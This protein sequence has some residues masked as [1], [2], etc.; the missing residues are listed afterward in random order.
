MNILIVE[1]DLAQ[2]DTWKRQIERNNVRKGL[3]YSADYAESYEQAVE[4]IDS[5]KYDAA[6]LDVRLQNPDG[7]KDAT[8][9]GN[10]VRDLLLRFEIVL[11]AHV[12]GEPKAIDF[13]D[14]KNEG[15]VRV[16]TKG[17]STEDDRSVHD[18][19]LDWLEEKSNIVITMKKVQSNIASKMAD[20]FYSS[21]WPRWESWQAVVD[22]NTEFI[23]SSITRHIASHLYNS[24]LEDDG[25]KV[26]SEE[27]YFQPP[28][29]NRFYTG[30]LVL[31]EDEYFVL[32]SPRCDL[33]RLSEG[34]GLLFAK[35]NIASG[36]KEDKEALD[37]KVSQLKN[38][39][40]RETGERKVKLQKD[41]E[42]KYAQFRRN[43]F[44]HKD[45]KFNFHFLPEVNQSVDK[46]HGPFFVD[47]GNI[48][49]VAYG[50]DAA[51]AM[52]KNK[53]AALSPEFL[54][55]LVQ[56]LGTFI[57]RIGSPDYSHV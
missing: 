20:L 9:G 3:E 23:P 36:W 37:E 56:R 50:S 46:V 16:F 34:D 33:E 29:T 4:L 18:M 39:L 19:V 45:G 14:S 51:D 41:I 54:P 15:L 11:I 49:T 44:G 48:H 38:E 13:G 6:I 7:V 30:D 24:F 26:H 8:T 12:T 53:I 17:D 43:Y 1:D 40:N 28:S 42:K 10:D 22:S 55:A 32:V 25:G 57:S 27:W 35:L 52:L 2:V 31:Y 5:K 47:F 21:I